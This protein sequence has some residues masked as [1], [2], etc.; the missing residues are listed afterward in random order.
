MQLSNH[1][2]LIAVMTELWTLLDTLA[3]VKPGVSLRLPPSDTGVHL[4]ST[5]SI[6]A[7]LAAGF[8]PKAV[9][10]MSV[11]PYLHDSQ[12]DWG[13]RAVNFGGSTFPLS[14]LH[15]EEEDFDHMREIYDGA[16]EMLRPSDFRFMWQNS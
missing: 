14:Y 3:I 10:V 12:P 7:A 2:D 8:A 5:F 1:S 15:F 11:L 13:Q 16:E 6:D 9:T 4:A